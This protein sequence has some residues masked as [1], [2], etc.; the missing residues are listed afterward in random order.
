[1]HHR[2]NGDVVS[3][4]HLRNLP[5]GTSKTYPHRTDERGMSRALDAHDID[6]FI[7]KEL[8]EKG[9]GPPVA[10]PPTRMEGRVEGEGRASASMPF[11]MGA[12]NVDPYALCARYPDLPGCK[13]FI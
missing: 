4:G 2:M 8:V 1:M 9:G 7:N 5:F 11:G 3:K 10:L 6:H 13:A 12:Q